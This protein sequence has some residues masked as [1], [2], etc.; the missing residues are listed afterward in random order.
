VAAPHIGIVGT[1]RVALALGRSLIA[2]GESVVAVAS[3]TPA[4]AD[5]AARFIG[6][7]VRATTCAELAQLATHVLIA[8]SDD[9]IAVA[10]GTL[11]SAGLR[12]GIV[13]HTA[14]A[15][16]LEPLAAL[17]DRGSSCGVLHPLHTI[18][19]PEAAG[20]F[21]GVTFGIAGDPAA[22]TWASHIAAG[23]GGCVL[24][25]RADRMGAYHAAAVLAGNALPALLDCAARLMADAGV[26][27][28]AALQA[29]GPLTRASAGNA[30]RMGPAA[31]LTGP[32]VR[33]DTATIDAHV[34]ALASAPA[35]AAALY[36][37]VSRSLIPLARR[38]GV[39]EHTLQ[40]LAAA[41]ERD[42]SGDRP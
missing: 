25:V 30:I 2:A 36:R 42:T 41:L 22:A 16:G 15:P 40:A 29:L 6:N 23:L 32:I 39:P 12:D 11:A 37:A 18:V 1:G 14:G 31:S 9:R 33:G 4:R 20:Q 7:R 8:T 34:K 38:R 17:R 19:D 10:A 3:R 27:Y 26:G 35:D 24:S 13:V 21:N 5:E 28:D